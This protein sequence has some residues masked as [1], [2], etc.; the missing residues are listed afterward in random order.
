MLAQQQSANI[1]DALLRYFGKEIKREQG[2]QKVD[3]SAE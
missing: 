2:A 3:N 1:F